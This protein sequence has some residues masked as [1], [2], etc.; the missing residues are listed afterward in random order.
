MNYYNINTALFNYVSLRASSTVA[1]HPTV[2][3]VGF[4][5]LHFVI[6]D[7]GSGIAGTIRH[8]ASALPGSGDRNADSH[9]AQHDRNI[10]AVI[11]NNTVF[12]RGEVQLRLQ[13]H[14]G[15]GCRSRLGSFSSFSSRA[16][17]Q[18]GFQAF[19]IIYRLLQLRKT[20]I[21]AVR[22]NDSENQQ[23]AILRPQ[24]WQV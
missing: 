18:Q 11:R 3:T 14:C 20:T 13:S 10:G 17:E 9:V 12:R 16:M 15:F 19:L 22:V 1:F 23:S 4:P 2:K 24:T 6:S 5:G 21:D 8:D 7:C